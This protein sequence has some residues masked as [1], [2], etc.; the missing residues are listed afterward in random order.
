MTPGLGHTPVRHQPPLLSEAK[1]VDEALQKQG[2]DWGRAA[3][4]AALGSRRGR[5]IFQ[6]GILNK[7]PKTVAKSADRPK[8]QVYEYLPLELIP[9][10]SQMSAARKRERADAILRKIGWE[11]LDVLDLDEDELVKEANR[12][13]IRYELA[14]PADN[15]DFQE[16]EHKKGR[17]RKWQMR[18]LRKIQREALVYVVA[19]VGAAGGPLR[20]GRPLYVSD[21]SLRLYR[22]QQLR[23]A[24]ILERLRLIKKLDPKCQIPLSELNIKAQIA[25]TTKRRLMVDMMLMRWKELGWTVCWITTTLPPQYV[26]HSTNEENRVTGWDVELGPKEAHAAIQID[27]H[28]VMALLRERGVRPSGWWNLQPQQSG[29]PHRH[30][31]IAVPT[32]E[33]ARLIC[34]TFKERFS[35]RPKEGQEDRGCAAFVIGDED[36][37]YRPRKGKD[38]K[39]ETVDSIA[40]YAARY[41]TR[42]E[43]IVEGDEV[44]LEDLDRLSTEFERFKVWKN[45]RRCRA[46][47]WLGLD[48]RR[49]PGELWDTLWANAMRSDYDPADA[50]MAIAMREMR[51]VQTSVQL[52]VEARKAAEGLG[53]GEDK[54]SFEETVRIANEDAAYSAWHAAVALG[55]WPD[56]DLDADELD[57]LR[58]AVQEWNAENGETDRDPLPPMPLREVKTSV[59]DEEYKK[60]T[61]VVGTVR[62]FDLEASAAVA[63]WLEVAEGLGIEAETPKVGKLKVRHVFKSLKDA[64]F[65]FSRRPDGRISGYDLSGEIL[66]RVL[67][68]WEIVDEETAKKR[69]E[70]AGGEFPTVGA[71]KVQNLPHSDE[72]DLLYKEVCRHAEK[73]RE[74]A[75]ALGF[76]RFGLPSSVTYMENFPND[77]DVVAY[78]ENVSKYNDLLA[79]AWEDLNGLSFSPTDPRIGP[80]GPI[81]GEK[82]SDDG[83]PD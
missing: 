11:G 57:W 82:T 1:N 47:A 78:S 25:D 12:T 45:E 10:Y 28:R 55:L 35:N 69:L 41:A 67:D 61:G 22:Q 34:D 74:K 18:R 53:E 51:D 3:D 39:E 56:T 75:E 66:M 60:T 4:S 79:K 72:R 62:R 37:N 40:R 46:H 64:G 23:T 7:Q 42:L 58:D 30:Y 20:D 76:T 48:A 9:F 17:C 21:Y 15:P 6:K 59:F 71:M 44:D 24:R 5:E 31:V 68:E 52:A 29:T 16:P 2:F 38:G 19:A 50:R 49:A 13:V 26:P 36:N 54:T 83:P 77:R 43:K 70:E 32:I 80:G 14:H 65:G 27:H 8:K 63:A 81:S 73:V 33:D